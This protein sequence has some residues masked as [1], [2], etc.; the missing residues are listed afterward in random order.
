VFLQ[1]VEN[2]DLTRYTVEEYFNALAAN[3]PSMTPE[4]ARDAIGNACAPA[5]AAAMVSGNKWWQKATMSAMGYMTGRIS[6]EA[7]YAHW[8]Q[9]ISELNS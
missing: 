3:L 1:D 8:T 6:K 5:R 7:I 9:T 2:K 4:Q